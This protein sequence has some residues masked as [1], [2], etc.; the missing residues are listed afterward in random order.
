MKRLTRSMAIY[1]K[2]WPAPER[3]HHEETTALAVVGIG[4]SVRRVRRTLVGTDVRWIEHRGIQLHALQPQP[5]CHHRTIWQYGG[6][7]RR[8]DAGVGAGQTQLLLQA[9][10]N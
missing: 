2:A 8:F 5:L 1:G 7:R 4:V 9:E 6:R 3:H 10:G